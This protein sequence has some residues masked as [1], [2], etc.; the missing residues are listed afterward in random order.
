[1]IGQINF[2]HTIRNLCNT[3]ALELL[4]CICGCW[5]QKKRVFKYFLRFK[6]SFLE[7]FIKKYRKLIKN[8]KNIR[9]DSTQTVYEVYIGFG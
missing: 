2:C 9:E 7:R 6:N 3:D 1:M 4:V 5:T 8:V